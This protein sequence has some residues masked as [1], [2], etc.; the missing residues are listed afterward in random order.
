MTR[1]KAFG[2]HLGI[3]AL[4]GAAAAAVVGL[5]WY[6]P[7]LLQATGSDFFLM[8]L[9][10]VDVVIGPLLTLVVFKQGKKT[11]KFDLTVI[12]LL[13]AGLLAYGLWT[14][15]SSRPVFLVEGVDRVTLVRANAIESSDLVAAKAAGHGY[16]RLSFTGPVLVGSRPPESV[17][18]RNRLMMEE[19]QGGLPIELRPQFF[20]PFGDRA[21]ALFR[22]GKSLPPLYTRAPGAMAD[23]TD[24][25]ARAG[26]SIDDLRFVPMVTG[27]ED[28]ALILSAKT[29]QPLGMVRVDPW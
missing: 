20:V 6:P 7:P 12:A 16:H 22:R 9:V 28:V 11:L 17:A 15:V 27:R 1:W 13:Q 5:V 25:A 26:E 18:E 8:V 23:I 10:G 4:I 3:S 2:I 24:I 14:A 19:L 21:E 29:F